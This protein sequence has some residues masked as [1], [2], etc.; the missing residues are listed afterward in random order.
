[1]IVWLLVDRAGFSWDLHGHGEQRAGVYRM[2]SSFPEVDL[3]CQSL[4]EPCWE[5]RVSLERR[6]ICLRKAGDVLVVFI[7]KVCVVM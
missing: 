7:P 3:H 4:G 1:M 2:Y 6:D 5:Q